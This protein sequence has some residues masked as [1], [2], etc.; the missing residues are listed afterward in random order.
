MS[1]TIYA[2]SSGFLPSGIAVVRISGDRAT[3]AVSALCPAGLPAP[4]MLMRRTLVSPGDGRTVL[5]EGMVVW[6][7]EP[8]T[9]SGEDYAELHLHGG[10]AVVAAVLDAL[11]GVRGCRMAEAGE[12]SRRAFDNGKLDLSAAEGLADLIAS[13]TEAQRRQALRQLG[14]HLSR[15]C[16]VWQD[17][18]TGALAHMEATIDFSDDELPDDLDDSARATIE[19]V[20]GEVAACL[21]DTQ[22]GER[23]REGIRIAIVGPPNAGKS[24]LLNALAGRNAV[25][26][27]EQAGT[28]RD[29]IEV[30]MEI[31]GYAVVLSDTAGLRDS[32]DAVE[33]EGVRRAREAAAQ[34]D[35][36]LVV[37]DGLAW[38][39][40]DAASLAWLD[41]KGIGVI[42][43]ADIVAAPVGGAAQA[44][45]TVNGQALMPVSATTGAGLA[46]LLDRLHRE[47]ANRWG[48]GTG[49]S[50]AVVIT[51]V[52]HREAMEACREHLARTLTARGSELWAEDLRLALRALG[53]IVGHVGVED[54]LDVIFG[55]FCIGK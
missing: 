54:I 47:I 46:A 26:T 41:E 21:N 15:Q 36:R 30:N 14:G 48:D 50:E 20:H 34:A 45:R 35:L 9:V 28:T 43:K 31:G 23:I 38:P 6:M 29:V 12:F 13:E 19:R 11:G 55:E 49:D 5:D 8:A 52:R 16:R 44:G 51:R 1:D 4:R 53:R 25:I 27:S 17:A 3:D 10:R 37:I 7:P 24:S 22:A 32:D 18:L 40:H 33:R 2:L 39:D 42:S